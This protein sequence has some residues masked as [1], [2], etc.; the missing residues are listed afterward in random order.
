MKALKEIAAAIGCAPTETDGLYS[1]A[2]ERNLARVL[3]AVQELLA[4]GTTAHPAFSGLSG[5]YDH[6][7]IFF[8]D[9]LGLSMLQN[10][11]TALEQLYDRFGQ[12][13]STVFPSITNVAITSFYTGTLPVEH[14]IPGFVIEMPDVGTRVDH[15]QLKVP[16]AQAA[17]PLAGF[18]CRQWFRRPTRYT[19]AS[20]G[21][22]DLYSFAPWPI[23]GSGLSS[24]TFGSDTFFHGYDYAI[25]GFERARLV[26][27]HGQRTVINYYQP[28]P[29]GMSHKFGP[30]DDETAFYVRQLDE[31]FAFFLR[32]LNPAVA[33]RTLFLFVADHGQVQTDAAVVTPEQQQVLFRGVTRDWLGYSGRV[34]HVYGTDDE[35]QQVIGT[36]R[37]LIGDTFAVLDHDAIRRSYTGGQAGDDLFWQRNGRYLL[38]FKPGHGLHLAQEKETRRQNDPLQQLQRLYNG[39][40]G[41][42]SLDELLIPVICANARACQ[43]K[44]F[45]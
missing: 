25:E 3:P 9:S 32:K 19:R 37:E 8:A 43:E 1:I 20:F 13:F 10:S 27:E 5:A 24:L 11:G 2:P 34:A 22:R 35:A 33:A 30:G 23:I 15:L 12:P 14:G 41:G 18:D 21:N 42:A 17:L 29:D 26:L 31:Q 38:S 28:G 40:H 45:A 7:F 6:L 39:Q 36:L 16:G 44:L 4:T